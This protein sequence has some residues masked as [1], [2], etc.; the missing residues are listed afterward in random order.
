MTVYSNYADKGKIAVIYSNGNV[1]IKKWY[2]SPKIKNGSTIIVYTEE[3]R[4]P[5][6]LTEVAK[7]ISSLVASVATILILVN[8]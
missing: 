8:Q 5:I 4:E 3:F 1:E 6:K 2:Y 7:N